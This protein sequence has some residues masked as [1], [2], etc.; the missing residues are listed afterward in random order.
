M[1]CLLPRRGLRRGSVADLAEKLRRSSMASLCISEAADSESAGE[2]CAA[3]RQ[4]AEAAQ[5]EAEEQRLPAALCRQRRLQVYAE[6]L[7]KEPVIL[8]VE[9]RR[10]GGS[11]EG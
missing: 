6:A 1:P 11:E 2:H 9:R 10:G 8:Q 5:A 4:A 3:A 7:L